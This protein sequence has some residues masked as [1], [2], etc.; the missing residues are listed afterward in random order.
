MNVNDQK[1]FLCVCSQPGKT[2]PWEFRKSRFFFINNKIRVIY[3]EVVN[4]IKNNK[5]FDESLIL[6]NKSR[7]FFS[8][9]FNWKNYPN[10]DAKIAIFLQL[11]R[12]DRKL[13][14]QVFTWED[15]HV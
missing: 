2:N 6:N 11:R 1:Y 4:I 9:F 5:F 8:L 15:L 13:R 7:T 12:Q 14:R 10:L 3:N